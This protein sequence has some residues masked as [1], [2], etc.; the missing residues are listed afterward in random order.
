MADNGSNFSQ[1]KILIIGSIAVIAVVAA[2][3]YYMGYTPQVSPPVN[4]NASVVAAVNGEEITDSDVRMI[5]QSFAIQGQDVSEQD[6][7]EY[8]ID[9]KVLVQEAREQ[10]LFP[11]KE[12]VEEILEFQVS[13]QGGTM[14]D[15]KEQIRSQGQSYEEAVDGYRS[16]VAIQQYIEATIDTPQVSP[17]EAREFYDQNKE[18]LAVGANTPSYEEVQDE[19]VSFLEIQKQQEAVSEL[20]QQLRSKA[21]IVYY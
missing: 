19:I 20:I 18:Q 16:Q 10:G 2:G 13:Q 9:R 21:S 17:S 5:R 3:L 11:S 15:L 4:A 1:R 12:E 7:I 8:T 14:D 6:A